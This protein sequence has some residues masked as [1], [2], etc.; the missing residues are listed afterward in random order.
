MQEQRSLLG[1]N[2]HNVFSL[3]I[4]KQRSY[5][6]ATDGAARIFLPP[7]ATAW[8]EPTSVELHQTETY[9]GHS[10]DWATALRQF[11]NNLSSFQIRFLFDLIDKNGAG[12]FH[13]EE[14]YDVLELMIGVNI[15]WVVHMGRSCSA[16]VEQMPHSL[17]VVGLNLFFSFPSCSLSVS[18]SL[19]LSLSL[20]HQLLRTEIASKQPQVK[21]KLQISAT[22]N[23]STS[24]TGLWPKLTSMRSGPLFCF[25]CFFCGNSWSRFECWWLSCQ[26]RNCLVSIF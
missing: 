25:F 15:E 7:Y 12:K 2:K 10:I 6:S 3:L 19:S 17:E 18:L 9:E 26:F 14:L 21:L 4:P 16:G 22:T 11:F 24:S 1:I 20:C 23:W 13:R 8:F 5:I